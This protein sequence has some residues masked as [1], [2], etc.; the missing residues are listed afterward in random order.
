MKNLSRVLILGRLTPSTTIRVS[1]KPSFVWCTNIDKTEEYQVW[2]VVGPDQAGLYVLTDI[3]RTT[4]QEYIV[5]VLP[6]LNA[7]FSPVVPHAPSHDYW[8]SDPAYIQIRQISW[9]HPSVSG[10]SV[11]IG[12]GWVKT[13]HGLKY[14]AGGTIDISAHKPTSGARWVLVTL[15]DDPKPVATVGDLATS[16]FSLDESFIPGLPFGH[17]PSCLIKLYGGQIKIRDMPTKPDFVDLRFTSF[18]GDA[19]GS[20]WNHLEDIPERI[21]DMLEIPTLWSGE[22]TNGDGDIVTVVDGLIVD[23]SPPSYP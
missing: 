6:S 3:D 2:S 7:V 19:A 16:L 21:T 17:T 11:V 1:G 22:F 13:T 12:A 14:L 18:G 5:R 15:D 9:L 4:G 8:G 23:V 20:S 10:F